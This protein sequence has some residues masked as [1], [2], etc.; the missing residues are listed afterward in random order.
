MLKLLYA[1][2]GREDRRAGLM[3]CT[4]CSM[5][6][7]IPDV[8]PSC[9]TRAGAVRRG[10]ARRQGMGAGVER[11]WKEEGVMEKGE[12][13]ERGGYGEASTSRIFKAGVSLPM[14]RRP[15]PYDKASLSL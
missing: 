8:L 1:E 14:T 9:S 12:G 13:E 2:G 11:K 7:S 15:S 4:S 6:K 10:T 3:W 5:L